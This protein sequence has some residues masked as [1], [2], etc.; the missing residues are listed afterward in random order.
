MIT[1]TNTVNRTPIRLTDDVAVEQPWEEPFLQADSIACS[2]DI[3]IASPPAFTTASVAMLSPVFLI[4]DLE[5]VTSPLGNVPNAIMI[6]TAAKIPEIVIC[7]AIVC[8]TYPFYLK[9][10]L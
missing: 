3:F 6:I 8:V 4:V 10:K 7:F 2:P 9:L 1:I 5:S